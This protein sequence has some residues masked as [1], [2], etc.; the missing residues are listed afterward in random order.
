MVV[1]RTTEHIA[2]QPR[3]LEWKATVV[4]KEKDFKPKVT[5]RCAGA[6]KPEPLPKLRVR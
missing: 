5:H 6:A 1:A 4:V 3:F 2:T